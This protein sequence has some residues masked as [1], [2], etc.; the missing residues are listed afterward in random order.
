MY[1]RSSNWNRNKSFDVRCIFR[2]QW[3]KTLAQMIF[4]SKARERNRWAVLVNSGLH[5]TWVDSRSIVFPVAIA[6]GHISPCSFDKTHL[7]DSVCGIS[8]STNDFWKCDKLWLHL[9]VSPVGYKPQHITLDI[10]LIPQ[11]DTTHFEIAPLWISS[12]KS[13]YWYNFPIWIKKPFKATF[14]PH[15]S[16]KE[17]CISG[18]T[19]SIWFI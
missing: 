10:P 2:S 1:P 13:P 18:S 19:F 8:L 9:Q 12:L 17:C 7:E 14:S 6:E 16:V 15:C 5:F 3:I 11:W 4:N